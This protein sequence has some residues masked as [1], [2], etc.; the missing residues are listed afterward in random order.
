[1]IAAMS[2]TVN[3]P[4]FAAARP[5]N[6]YVKTIHRLC[7]DSGHPRRGSPAQIGS[8]MVPAAVRRARKEG[9]MTRETAYRSVL[10]TVSVFFMC[11]ALGSTQSGTRRPQE[12]RGV[13]VVSHT[14]PVSPVERR[15]ALVIGNS[16][17]Q[18]A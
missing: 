13:T 17:Y 16:Q 9:S 2:P 15:V 14:P 6:L 1:M 8:S 3:F 10:I 11:T 5:L 18:Y 12:P 4:V 7:Y